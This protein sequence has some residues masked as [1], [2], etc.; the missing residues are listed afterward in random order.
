KLEREQLRD[1]VRLQ[2]TDSEE[3]LAAQGIGLTVDDE[4]VDLIADRGYEPEYGARPLRRVIQRELDD[5]VADLLVASEVSEGDRVQ[6]TVADGRLHVAAE[7]AVT[8]A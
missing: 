6:V 8:A 2:L 5:A 4:A 3:R 1:I 7:T